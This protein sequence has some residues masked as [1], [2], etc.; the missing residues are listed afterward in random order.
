MPAG[1]QKIRAAGDIPHAGA[2]TSA[3]GNLSAATLLRLRVE[4]SPAFAAFRGAILIYGAFA[5]GFDSPSIIA[6]A[7]FFSSTSSASVIV[8]RMPNVFGRSSGVMPLL[9]QTPCRSGWPSGIR[10]TDQQLADRADDTRPRRRA[11]LDQRV[12]AL[13]VAQCVAQHRIQSCN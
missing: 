6:W 5:V 13:L 10:G 11:E 4:R 8:A 7:R 1:I 3:G 2:V 12:Q 9:A